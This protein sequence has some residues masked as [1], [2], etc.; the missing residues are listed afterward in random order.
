MGKEEKEAAAPPVFSGD[1]VVP[2]RVTS[3]T[4]DLCCS[5]PVVFCQLR[6]KHIKSSVLIC[7]VIK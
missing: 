2:R 7:T 3:V 4:V 6:S 5:V 1:C